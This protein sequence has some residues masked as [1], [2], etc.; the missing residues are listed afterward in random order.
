MPG[1]SLRL[2]REEMPLGKAGLGSPGG[3]AGSPGGNGIAEPLDIP[4]LTMLESCSARVRC[5][6]LR[7]SST[8]RVMR[9]WIAS[10]SSLA[11]A[12][13]NRLSNSPFI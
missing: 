3:G 2:G 1:G 5:P 8:T 13:N 6:F 10:L 9:L 11:I 7:S 4:L 12:L